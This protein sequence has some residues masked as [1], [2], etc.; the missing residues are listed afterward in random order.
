MK[1]KLHTLLYRPRGVLW[2]INHAANINSMLLE[3]YI[4]FEANIDVV[5]IIA[6]SHKHIITEFSEVF[7][8]LFSL[9]VGAQEEAAFHLAVGALFRQR[10]LGGSGEVH[11]HLLVVLV[12]LV[13]GLLRHGFPELEPTTP[14]LSEADKHRVSTNPLLSMRP[15]T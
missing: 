4:I 11:R 6:S 13:F 3:F 2:F 10:R 5:S 12:E 8:F 9:K 14:K 1:Y 15:I 7:Y